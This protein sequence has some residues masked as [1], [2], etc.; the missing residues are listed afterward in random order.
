MADIEKNLTRKLYRAFCPD[1]MELDDYLLGEL[2]HERTALI[3]AHVKECPHCRREL[4]QM[5]T[6]LRETRPNLELN[7]I[8]RVRVLV[9]RLATYGDISRL[10]PELQGVRGFEGQ[11][12]T[13][14]TEGMK[15][16]LDL[17]ADPERADLRIIYGMLVGAEKAQ[18]FQVQLLQ[19]NQQTGATAV[20]Q[21]GNFELS[22]ITPGRYRLVLAG[23][24]VEIRVEDLDV[25]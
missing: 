2:P 12:L 8:E 17:Q 23:P 21:F 9:A 11:V 24:G 6:F 16:I 20:D 1:S 25:R 18:E 13:Y 10:S 22:S 15:A 3:R 19:D 14:E 7:L 4:E 5:R